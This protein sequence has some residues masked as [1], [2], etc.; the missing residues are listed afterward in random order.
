VQDALTARLDRL[1]TVKETA[2]I[3]A[4]I[5][6]EFSHELM[7]AVTPLP[8]NE[9]QD[10]LDRLFQSGLI[11]RRGSPSNPTYI[12]KHALVQDA[13]YHSLLKKKRQEIHRNIAQTLEERFA[14][15]AETQPELLAHHFTEAGLAEPAIAYW[16]RAGR[17]ATG[18][19]AN[20]EAV[21]HLT[22]GLDILRK[23]PATPGRTRQELALQIA[24]GAPLQALKGQAAPE[25]AEA[26]R[27]ARE[28]CEQLGDTRQL[29]TVLHGLHAFHI[30]RGELPAAMD[31]A[32]EC[33]RLAL[34]EEDGALI[35]A[36]LFVLGC[37]SF[38][39]AKLTSARENFEK[40]LHLYDPC[41]RAP[42]VLPAGVDLGVFGKS[43][44]SH[45][46]WYLGYPDRA[47]EW[48]RAAAADA[49]E[50]S[51]FFSRAVAAAYAAMLMQFL[52]H[53]RAAKQQADAAIALCTEHKFAYYLAWARVIRGWALAREAREDEGIMEMRE[54]LAALRATGAGLRRP[55]YLGILAESLGV[56]GQIEEASDL[57]ASALA[58][59]AEHGDQFFSAELHRIE[60]EL[61]G[62]RSGPEASETSFS[63]AVAIARRQKARLTELRAATSLA[64]L[65][66]E[67][68]R[69]A[70]AH[71]LLAP[72]YAW[73]TEGFDTADLKDARALL[74]ELR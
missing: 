65:W 74:D 44:L 18:R 3:G 32:E 56:A 66:R 24:L 37:V 53:A 27:R 41:P 4:A 47:V 5:G 23:T 15:T 63:Q 28:L 34:H 70:E 52:G 1:A 31:L 12:F 61:L 39:L 59:A 11:F 69:R 57:V 8:E 73:F 20:R 62:R 16:H 43:Y 26:F 17:R 72:I 60:G 10:A 2:Q 14:Q 21:S 9:L 46:V 38:H 35:A 50:C 48:S 13:A 58:V 40:A 64:R 33:Y 51:H 22:K 71:D 29:S 55:Y 36:A 54:A 45:A 25:A 67:Q 7:A 68:G 49:A 42:R 19:S 6:R 30:V